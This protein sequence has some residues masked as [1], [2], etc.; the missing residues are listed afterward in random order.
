MLV[1]GEDHLEDGRLLLADQGVPVRLPQVGQVDV[2]IPPGAEHLRINS[3]KN[4]F[5]YVCQ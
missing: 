5:I 2:L 3:I 4:N 1:G